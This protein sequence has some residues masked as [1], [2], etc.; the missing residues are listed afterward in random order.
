MNIEEI[1]GLAICAKGLA[2]YCNLHEQF[3]SVCVASKRQQSFDCATYTFEARI[4]VDDELFQ[5]LP[6]KEEIEEKDGFI[7]CRK[8]MKGVEFFMIKL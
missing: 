8:V 2:D 6:G 5:T 4:H 1:E 3:L 7:E